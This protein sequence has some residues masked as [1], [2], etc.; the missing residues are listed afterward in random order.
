MLQSL[1]L[2]LAGWVWQSALALLADERL[3]DVGNDSTAGDG[4]LDQS[5]QLFISSDGQLKIITVCKKQFRTFYR[6][7]IALNKPLKA[8]NLR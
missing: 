3:V 6:L 7:R 5:V 8:K 2:T 1:H 4:R